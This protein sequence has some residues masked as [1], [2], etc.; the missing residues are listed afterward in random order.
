MVERVPSDENPF[1]NIHITNVNWEKIGYRCQRLIGF[2]FN[3]LQ[4]PTPSEHFRGAPEIDPGQLEI[5]FPPHPSIL[6]G[7]VRFPYGSEGQ[8]MD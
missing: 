2:L 6:N 4:D 8:Y 1:P 7:V 5:D 3:H